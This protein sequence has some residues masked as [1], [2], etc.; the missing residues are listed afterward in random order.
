MKIK[1]NILLDGLNFPEG[2]AFDSHGRLWC[3]ELS[4]G[5]LTRYEGDGSFRRY[6]TNG[7]PNGLLFDGKGLAWFCDSGQNAVRTFDGDKE[8]FE[9]I[10]CSVEGQRLNK[11]NDLAFDEAGNL[12]FTCPGHSEYEPTGYVCCMKPS[13]EVGYIAQ[14]MYFPNGLALIE[15]GSSLVVAET[16]KH[17]LWKGKWDKEA[18]AWLDPQPWAEVGG[19]TGPDGMALGEDGLLYVAVFGSG[20]IKAVSP[21]GKVVE[22][23]ELPGMNPTNCAFDPNGRLGLVVT[24]AE[25]GLL[26]SLPELGKGGA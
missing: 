18:G 24:E 11:P 25:K 22:T 6:P 8:H 12:I 16:F 19:P 10:A 7:S 21:E 13:G 14:N 15:N 5:S 1:T 3:V 4:G 20:M 26:L 17:R 9:E 23:Y 2:P